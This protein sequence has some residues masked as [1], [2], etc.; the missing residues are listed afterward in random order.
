MLKTFDDGCLKVS[1]FNRR[2]AADC[3]RLPAAVNRQSVNDGGKTVAKR[4]RAADAEINGV[5]AGACSAVAVG[6]VSALAVGVLDGASQAAFC[7]GA[8]VSRRVDD[9]RM[10]T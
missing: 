8:R 7:G 6:R 1:H 4:D 9:Y 5:G 2:T 10:R 3:N